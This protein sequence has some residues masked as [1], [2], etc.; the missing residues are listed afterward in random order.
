MSDL[1]TCHTCGYEAKTQEEVTM[2]FK[3]GC[4]RALV[5]KGDYTN[6]VELCAPNRQQGG[7]YAPG[8]HPDTQIEDPDAMHDLFCKKYEKKEKPKK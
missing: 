3:Y 8:T 2:W 1:G 7:F 4:C 6:E 5:K